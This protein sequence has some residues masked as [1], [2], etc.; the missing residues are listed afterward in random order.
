M[1]RSLPAKA[2]LAH[3]VRVLTR[4]VRRK[5]KAEPNPSQWV[6]TVTGCGDTSGEHEGARVR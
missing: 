6:I 5:I 1:W 2:R 4:Q 3:F